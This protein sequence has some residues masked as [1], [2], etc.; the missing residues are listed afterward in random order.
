MGSGATAIN[1]GVDYGE[2]QKGISTSDSG[3]LGSCMDTVSMFGS[4]AIDTRVNSSRV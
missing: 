4:T 3:T 1:M 2:V